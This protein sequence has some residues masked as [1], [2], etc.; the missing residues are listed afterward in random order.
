MNNRLFFITLDPQTGTVSRISHP[1]DPDFMNWCGET[2]AWGGIHHRILRNGFKPDPLE[3]VEFQQR[4]GAAVCMYENS[5]LQVT[6]ERFFDSEGRFTERYTFQNL[7]PVELFLSRG[8]LAVE[9]NLNDMYTDAEDCMTG[10]C[11][12]H[13]WCGG[14]T[15]Y[16]NALRMGQSDI[17]LG[18]VVTRGFVDSYSQNGTQTNRRGTF[19]LNCGHEILPPEGETVL[20][21]KL[22][23]HGGNEDF[24]RQ[25]ARFP[26][27][28]GIQAENYTVFSGETISFRVDTAACR[29]LL[30]GKEIPCYRD[31]DGARVEYKPQR[32]G[33]HRFTVQKGDY[34]TWADFFVAETFETLLQ[35]RLRFIV[36]KQQCN[37]PGS[38]LDGAFLIYDNQEKHLVFDHAITDHNACRE[39]VGMGLLLAKYLQTHSDD[40]LRAALDR[41][42]AFVLREVYDADTGNVRDSLGPDGNLRLYNAPWIVMLFTE[43]YSLTQ[44]V[45]WLR[46]SLKILCNYYENG[47]NRFYPNGFSIYKTAKAFADAGLESEYLQV[48]EWFLLHADNMAKNGLLYPKHEVNYEQT[49]VTPAATFLSEAALL[50]GDSH[51]TEEA[52]KHIGVLERFNGLQPSFHLHQIPIRYWDD[53]WFGKSHLFGDVFPH[54]WSC[55]TARSFRDYAQASGEKTYQ[56]LAEQCMRNCL[57]LFGENGEGSCAYVYPFRLN[58]TRGEFYDEWANDQD[59]ALYFALELDMF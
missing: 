52:G 19:L 35:K 2:G 34:T 28:I 48:T 27:F 33:A 50:T 36:E 26:Q 8:D 23:W 6:V 56:A 37:S 29:V 58:E 17:N 12:A 42:V 41:F 10:R 15:A 7:R 21:W 22:F 20:E 11:N 30:D 46:H 1:E 16:I 13:L 59:F 3:L 44:D 55:L 57:C 38:R 39:R 49:I 53:Y 47:G 14:N 32:L 45:V 43:L 31:V 4:G 24:Y 51:Y 18:L 54:Y 25:A 9:V 5:A 40:K